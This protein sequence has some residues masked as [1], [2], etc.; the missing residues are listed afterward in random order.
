MVYVYFLFFFKVVSFISFYS[1]FFNRF[2]VF[3]LGFFIL[4]T[5]FGFFFDVNI[6]CTRVK[7]W[8]VWFI[9]VFLGF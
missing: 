1:G 6:S 4:L 7:I 5:L 9:V 3:F 8:F 2:E